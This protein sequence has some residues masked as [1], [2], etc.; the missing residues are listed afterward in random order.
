MVEP[1]EDTRSELTF[2]TEPVLSALSQAIP[3]ASR[4]SPVELDEIEVRQ[5][6]IIDVS[7]SVSCCVLWDVL[8]L[9]CDP[10]V[11]HILLSF[12]TMMAST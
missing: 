2:A 8:V 6:L 11:P 12:T 10:H 1:L 5:S 4:G 7:L 3:G 9:S